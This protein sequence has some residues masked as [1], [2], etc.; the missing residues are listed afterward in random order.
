M[1]YLPDITINKARF[2]D[3]KVIMGRGLP[4]LSKKLPDWPNLNLFTK[5]D[6]SD[7]SS[8]PYLENVLFGNEPTNKNCISDYNFD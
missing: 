5:L 4:N 6:L 1:I 8:V 3:L 7:F 2:I